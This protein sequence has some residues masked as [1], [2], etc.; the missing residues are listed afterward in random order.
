MAIHVTDTV[1]I[2]WLGAEDLA[3]S[4]LATQLFFVVFIIC[5]GFAHAL[6]PLASAAA[7]Q[8]D[9]R[10]VRR[11][12]RMGMWAVMGMALIL[13]PVLWFSDAL[14][15][16]LGQNPELTIISQDYLRIA[17]LGIFPTVIVAVM[18]SYLAA[19]ER[20]GI[21]FGATISGVVLNAFLNWVLIFG[22]LGAPALGIEG[23]AIASVGTVLLTCIVL[24]IYAR[25]KSDLRRYAIF[26][27]MWRPDWEALR[28]IF[29]MG[30]AISA[31]LL[32]EVGLFAAASLMIGRIGTIEL[33]AHGIALQVIS[34]IFMIPLGLSSAATV[35]AGRAIGRRDRIGLGRAGA[36]VL[37]L[38]LTIATLAAVLLWIIPVPLIGLFLDAETNSE[39]AAIIAYGVPLLAVAGAFQIVDT[40]QVISVG[41]LRGIKDIK[42][43]MLMAVISYW[44]VGVPTAWFLAFRMDMG[45]VGVWTGLAVGLGLSS[46]LLTGRF[47]MRDRL[48]LVKFSA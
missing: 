34:V 2:G 37:L 30:L 4:V 43:P 3:A 25:S 36:T 27:R 32:A 16:S 42:V 5:T 1:M 11:A 23:A 9:A 45:G 21:V 33:A 14:L 46:L 39:T 35:R 40:L 10:G 18:R 19:L 12:T 48:H 38:A 7:A 44:G 29:R 15:R 8:H 41:L 20:A 28:E 24:V 13:A 22:N 6:V 47:L 17:F 31:T 26:V